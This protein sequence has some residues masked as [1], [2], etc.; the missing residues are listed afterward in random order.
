MEAVDLK[1]LVS[2]GR[3]FDPAAPDALEQLAQ[4]AETVMTGTAGADLVRRVASLA[5]GADGSGA[6]DVERAGLAFVH[7]PSH[8]SAVDVL[9]E[10]G[11]EAGVRTHRPAVLRGCIKALQSCDGANGF[12]FHGYNSVASGL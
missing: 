4:F 5:G 6:T 2:F 7:H 9:V 10:I 3:T 11:R 1:D 8:R 12:D